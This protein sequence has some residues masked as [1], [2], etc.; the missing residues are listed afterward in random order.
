MTLRRCALLAL[1]LG[2]F[3]AGLPALVWTYIIVSGLGAV[4]NGQGGMAVSL[5]LF[6]LCVVGALACGIPAFIVGR[7]RF[8]A[9]GRPELRMKFAGVLLSLVGLALALGTCI[10]P[11]AIA[12]AIRANV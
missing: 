12:R 11:I 8:Q 3:A 5:V 2:L 10:G 7:N 6:P 1:I 9:D 4:G